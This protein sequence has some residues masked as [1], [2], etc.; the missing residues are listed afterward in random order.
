MQGQ[1]TIGDTPSKLDAAIATE[2]HAENHV[3]VVILISETHRQCDH[4]RVCR[5]FSRASIGL[6]FNLLA[7]LPLSLRFATF[8]LNGK[9]GVVNLSLG[10]G[11]QD[12]ISALNVEERGP[13]RALLTNIAVWMPAHSGPPVGPFYFFARRVCRDIQG[14][15]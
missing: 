12:G 5:C 10:W 13:C 9:H 11:G 6:A 3:A 14:L 4:V 2:Q 1:R 8:H 7:L 15:I